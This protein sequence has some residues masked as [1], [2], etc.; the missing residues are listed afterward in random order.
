MNQDNITTFWISKS[1]TLSIRDFM[2]HSLFGLQVFLQYEVQCEIY[3]KISF[4]YQFEA[5]FGIV[6]DNSSEVLKHL[7]HGIN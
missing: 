1:S 7:N 3:I 2:F 6:S 4:E 5:F